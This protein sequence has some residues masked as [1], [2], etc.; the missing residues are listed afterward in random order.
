MLVNVSIGEIIDKLNIL[1]IKLNRINDNNKKI[2]ITKEIN[3]LNKISIIKT[4][5]KYLYNILTYVNTSIWDLTDIIK[6]LDVTDQ[7]YPFI[8]K[9]IFD[10]NQK[11]FRIKN[12]FNDILNSD[13]KEQK[14]YS[15]NHCKIIINDDK[16]LYKKIA[17][18]FYL[19]IEYDSISF[20]SNNKYLKKIFYSSNFIYDKEINDCVTI[21]L[22]EIQLPQKLENV[23]KIDCIK[24]LSPG[25][26]GDFIHQ[27]SVIYE[28]Y[29]NTGRKGILYIADGFGGDPFRNGAKKTYEDIYDII[30]SQ[31]YIE[32]FRVYNNEQIDINLSAWRQ[33]QLLFRDNFYNIY[34]D[35]YKVDWASNKWL[36]L[37][38]D[39]KWNDK[40]LLHSSK[41]RYFN[42]LD[43][44]KLEKTFGDKILFISFDEKEY[45]Y[46]KEKSNSSIPFYHAKTFK[47][48]CIAINSCKLFIGA[49]SSPLSIAHA[50]YK[51]RIVAYDQGS[52]DI[53]HVYNLKHI[54]KNVYYSI[55]DYINS[56]KNK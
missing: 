36:T 4:K 1:E 44:D 35:I 45:L 7:I 39:D 12:T 6:S 18:I 30:I 27:L 41:A 25:L 33:H 55:E 37:E 34:K 24:Y 13:I 14:S 40:I 21:E 20:T 16:T 17:H 15:N 31:E 51:D 48:I 47:D 52:L 32:E 3:E 8:S 22:D 49:L 43:I 10:L 23:F 46:F 28:I 42:G 2:Q 29:L 5:Y 38:T 54:W 11:R 26:L 19:S 50:L 9:D 53:K 56:H